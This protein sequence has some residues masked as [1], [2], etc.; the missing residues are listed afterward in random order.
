MFESKFKKFDFRGFM[1]FVLNL[2]DYYG[3]GHIVFYPDKKDLFDK[4]QLTHIAPRRSINDRNGFIWAWRQQ[5]K[6]VRKVSFDQFSVDNNKKIKMTI[7]LDK[8]II[9]LD[10]AEGI[11]PVIIE[12][13]FKNNFGIEQEVINYRS[14]KIDIRISILEFISA[15]LFSVC[16]T[17]IFAIIKIQGI[18]FNFKPVLV[19]FVV[20]FSIS[21]SFTYLVLPIVEI[22]KKVGLGVKDIF[23]EFTMQ[24]KNKN[25]LG[26]FTTCFSLVA[27]I[28]VLYQIICLICQLIGKFLNL[29]K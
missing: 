3:L 9:R 14:Q 11:S 22:S 7:D 29:L 17:L 19:Y 13:V 1:D 18:W 8:L 27:G 16:F 10:S 2:A 12:D 23:S 20:F 25:K 24:F 5:Q 28:F 4:I 6:E 21:L 26:K 15:L